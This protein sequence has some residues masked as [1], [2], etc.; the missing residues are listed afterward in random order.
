[1]YARK[2][3]AEFSV[4]MS[5]SVRKVIQSWVEGEDSQRI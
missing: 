4:E 3:G 2:F 5:R 1:M